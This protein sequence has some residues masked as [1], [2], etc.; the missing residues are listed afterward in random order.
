M[1]IINLQRG[2]PSKRRTAW[3]N[4]V[5]IVHAQHDLSVG[6]GTAGRSAL[7]PFPLTKPR[8]LINSSNFQL[9][10]ISS[11]QNFTKSKFRLD[12]TFAFSL[13]STP[14]SAL[15]FPHLFGG[16]SGQIIFP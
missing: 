8:Y 6:A 12:S 4:G 2:I 5:F 10:K 13:F 11:S 3:P 7:A 1:R 14:V 16:A 9:F 15:G